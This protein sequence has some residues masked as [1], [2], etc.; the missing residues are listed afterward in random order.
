MLGC[1]DPSEFPKLV[2]SVLM[3]ISGTDSGADSYLGTGT[4]RLF[5][6]VFLAAR[7][8]ATAQVHSNW[9]S[10]VIAIENLSCDCDIETG[11]ASSGAIDTGGSADITTHVH[12]SYIR[13]GVAAGKSATRPYL[14]KITTIN[15][16]CLA[17]LPEE[18][19]ARKK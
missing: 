16:Y 17:V 18:S 1:S 3:G 19:K 6:R 10:K 5:K 8:I 12:L 9:I 4:A 7:S 2:S 15:S 11:D 13:E 14:T